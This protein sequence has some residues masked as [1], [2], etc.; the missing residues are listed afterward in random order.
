MSRHT[1]QTS[2]KSDPHSN[3]L[4]LTVLTQPN[5]TLIYE[6]LPFKVAQH[7]HQDE[8]N[9]LLNTAKQPKINFFAID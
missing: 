6:I 8:L 3:K 5:K 7:H 4:Q 2:S 1:G 9:L